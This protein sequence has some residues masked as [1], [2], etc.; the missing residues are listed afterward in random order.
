MDYAQSRPVHV[1][2]YTL[3]GC[4]VT[5]DALAR[6]NCVEF[7]KSAEDYIRASSAQAVVVN[8]NWQVPAQLVERHPPRELLR[9][10]L[11]SLFAAARRDG[12]P[13]LVTAA[14]PTVRY[15]HSDEITAHLFRDSPVDGLARADCADFARRAA[16]L[17]ADLRELADSAGVIVVD[18][19]S[20][21]CHAGLVP[22]I[23]EDRHL[24]FRDGNHVST[25]AARRWGGSLFAPFIES[26]QRP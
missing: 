4:D 11:P 24:M 23:S 18:P 5:Y 19:A 20:T 14:L 21:M 16:G 25:I 2:F 6:P 10:R 8:S 26:L 1:E 22:V 15:S 12:R 9:L 17:N 13:T 7:W 3:E